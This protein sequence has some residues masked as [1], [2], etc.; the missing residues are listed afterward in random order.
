MR[1]GNVRATGLGSKSLEK[2]KAV[3]VSPRVRLAFD[4]PAHHRFSIVFSVE[5]LLPTAWDCTT[6]GAS[7][8]RADGVRA[9]AKD[10]KPTRTH[11]DRLRERRS[12]PEL[13]E[14][15]SERLALLRSGAIGPNAY[16]RT[17]TAGEEKAG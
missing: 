4:C 14:I 11:W 6:C 8:V 5:A 17:T 15:L 16:E 3:A 2:G 1:S 13:E 12:L 7:A 10:V 9:E